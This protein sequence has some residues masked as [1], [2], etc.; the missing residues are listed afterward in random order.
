M[1]LVYQ[2]LKENL[3]KKFS[4]D[5][6]TVFVLKLKVALV[7]KDLLLLSSCGGCKLAILFLNIFVR[8][9]ELQLR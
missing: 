2:P 8:S 4:I 1:N 9:G 6:L 5:S 3:C 7:F